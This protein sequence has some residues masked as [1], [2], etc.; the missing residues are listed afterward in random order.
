MTLNVISF[1]EGWMGI[2]GLISL[3]IL[4]MLPKLSFLQQ[5]NLKGQ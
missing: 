4:M 5:C 3:L 1:D 2:S